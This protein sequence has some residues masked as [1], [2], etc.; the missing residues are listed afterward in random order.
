MSAIAARFI[1][2][3]DFCKTIG[4][5]NLLGVVAG[6]ILSPFFSFP[7][8]CTKSSFR[9]M[10]GVFIL[11]TVNIFPSAAVIRGIHFFQFSILSNV[12]ADYHHIASISPAAF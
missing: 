2:N 4:R 11:S 6:W 9:D 10:D 3:Y 8:L 7:S 1:D 12:L 5:S